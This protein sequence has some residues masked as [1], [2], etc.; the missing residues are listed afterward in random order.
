MQ[1]ITNNMKTKGLIIS[2]LLIYQ[3][4][5][6]QTKSYFP[7]ES[8]NSVVLLE[9]KIDTTFVPH[10]TGFLMFSYDTINPFIVVTNEHVLRNN[11]VYVTVPADQEL[12]NYMN[13]HG[14][15]TITIQNTIWT[16]YGEK[17][18]HKFDLV[19]NK[20][21]VC[22]KELDIA[23]FRIAIGTSIPLTDT[24][25]LKISAVK[26]IPK[27]MIK[28]KKDIPLG[29]N[30]YFIGFPFSIGTDL[31]WYYKGFTGLFSES[32][33]TPLVRNGSVAWSSD[34]TNIF[35]LDAFSYS[36]NSGSP[37]FTQSD[38]QNKPFL[39]G[40]I[41]GHLPSENSENIGLA[42]CTWVDAIVELI[43]KLK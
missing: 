27:S 20:S 8:L 28:N 23:A 16:L 22:N 11:Y 10:G 14:I 13:S 3:V 41:S 7:E 19:E 25:N 18:R 36:G 32:V 40:I 37:I 31:G 42:T 9:K 6:G 17:L 29:T 1:N 24:T 30:T 26:G 38:I 43:D 34:K 21:F 12:I 5:S 2:L 33:P 35:L 15:K 4:S 39:I